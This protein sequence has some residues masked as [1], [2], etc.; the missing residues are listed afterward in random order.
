M[1]GIAPVAQPLPLDTIARLLDAVAPRATAPARVPST[2]RAQL[3]LL[4]GNSASMLT[5]Q[6]RAL[7]GAS[8]ALTNGIQNADAGLSQTTVLALQQPALANGSADVRRGPPT[9]H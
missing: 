1:P 6:T 5:G 9:F 3:P 8:G 2:A 4:P 7:G